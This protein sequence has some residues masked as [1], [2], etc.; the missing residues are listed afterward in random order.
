MT[1]APSNPSGSLPSAV[2]QVEAPVMVPAHVEEKPTASHELAEV[3]QDEKG[4]AQIAHGDVEV[5]NLGWNENKERV[6]APLV[7]GLSNEEL[8]A[9][10]RRFDKQIF[11]VKSVDEAPVSGLFRVFTPLTLRTQTKDGSWRISISTLPT[12]R[13]SLPTSSGRI[14]SAST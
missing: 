4:E 3:E 12:T 7:G 10:I 1:D 9:L 5:K 11:H 13:N 8:W 2:A 6:A 14:W